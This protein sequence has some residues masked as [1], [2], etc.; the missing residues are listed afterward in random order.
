MKMSLRLLAASTVLA[1]AGAAFAA[2]PQASTAP[3]AS[4]SMQAPAKVRTAQQQRM[5]DCNKEATGKKGAERKAF[6]SS[7]LKGKAAAAPAM[8][9]AKSAQ[10]EKM[11]ACNAEAKT[12]AMKGAARKT[13]MSGCLKGGEAAPAAK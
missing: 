3:A 11:K 5:A 13:F 10:H 1:F 8:S 4:H 7:C 2:T 12:K 9:S 6:M